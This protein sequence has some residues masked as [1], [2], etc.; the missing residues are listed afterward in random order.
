MADERRDRDGTETRGSR[1]ARAR[2]RPPQ[3][4]IPA[5]RRERDRLRRI[6]R[7]R[8][9]A[10]RPVPPVTLNE[11]FVLTEELLA[12]AACD[13][14]HRKWLAVLINNEV[15]RPRLAGV[16][17]ERRLL[18]LP[19]CLRDADRCEG[20]FDEIGLVCRSCGRC[21]IHR[22]KA[23]AEGLGYVVLVSE[24]T[25]VVSALIRSGKIDAIIGVSCLSVLEKI[26]PLMEAAAVPAYAV[27]LLQDGC[28]DTSLDLDWV[29][30]VMHLTSQD[31]T[32]RIAFDALRIE[33]E[34][35]FGS[36]SLDSLLGPAPGETARLARAWLAKSGKRWRP[37]LVAGVY[38]ALAGAAGAA[39]AP[40]PEAVRQVACAVECFHKASLVHDD[41]ED[42]DE[43][44]YG[45]KTVHAEYGI[46]VA[47][48]VGDYLIGDGY[49]LLGEVELPAE[50]RT[51]MLAA[52]AEGHLGLATGQ[53]AELF[54]ARRPR[55]LSSGEVLEIFRN[56]TAPAFAVAL[57][58]G[59]TCAGA[60]RELWEHLD[61]YSEALGIA[62]QIRD[63]LE[64][65][66]GQGA[67]SDADSARPSIVL[68]L[69]YE[70]AQGE[71]RALLEA[72]WRRSLASE[73]LPRARRTIATG[74]AVEI[75]ERM[76]RDQEQRA[77][78][79]LEGL[80]SPDLKGLLRRVIGAIFDRGEEGAAGEPAARDAHG[81]A[82]GAEPAA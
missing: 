16:P 73:D 2:R 66:L 32:E 40:I 52:A 63:D 80:S 5:T 7:D 27:P 50:E 14:I 56:K 58:L 57:R 24:G 3:E 21:E 6:V 72:L 60:G 22:L 39:G 25:A 74:G 15:W 44:R 69:A 8:L 81:R 79:A 76:L 29:R 20:F 43:E 55:P 17:F 77:I 65:I 47:L 11:L 4:T 82:R 31:V 10:S 35:W 38:R 48:N 19:K 36:A 1:A 46:P 71:E 13:P 67:G 68:A 53:G 28:V 61:R 51:R 75:A 64:D 23:E 18:L 59:A 54:W 30:E 34:S 62:Y 33:V 49:R 41:I 9:R 12:Q 45:E 26:F 70:R 37:F 42:A 78:R